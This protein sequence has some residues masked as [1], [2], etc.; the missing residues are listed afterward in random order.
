MFRYNN[1]NL[2]ANPYM[3]TFS[4]LEKLGRF[5]AFMHKSDSTKKSVL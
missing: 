2:K 3:K 1:L 4:N 5:R